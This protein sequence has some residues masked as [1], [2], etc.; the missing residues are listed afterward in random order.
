MKILYCAPEA[1]NPNHYAYG[2][3][4]ASFLRLGLTVVDFDYLAESAALGQAGMIA[5]LE[6]LI[7]QEQP[8][9]FYHAIIEDE[10]PVD[11]LER[12]KANPAIT[13]MVFFSDDDWRMPHSLQWVG[14]YDVATTNDIDAM[15]LYRAHGHH[16]V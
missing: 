4:R 6:T 1:T 12:L 16:H 5:K 13:T 10:L 2:N 8:D 7:V 9:L 3:I 11:F 15:S 14:H